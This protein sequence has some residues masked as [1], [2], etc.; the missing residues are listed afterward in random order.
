VWSDHFINV[1]ELQI[2]FLDKET[3]LN[4]LK[5]PIDKFPDDAISHAIAETIFERVNG[6][7]YLLQLYAYL[8][9][10]E[11]NDANRSQANI[12][13]VAYIEKLVLSQAKYYFDSIFTSAPK[14]V[15]T[16]LEALAL[17]QTPA[18]DLPS[19]R[20]LKRRYL[21]NEQQKIAI[22]VLGAWIRRQYEED[23]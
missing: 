21:L 16:I 11:L 23:F 18:I 8:L 10:N 15:Q 13:D 17:G 9:V 6:Q 1:Q 7:P 2:G 4:L 22:P 3:S 5:K 19:R 20:W 12:E 14:P